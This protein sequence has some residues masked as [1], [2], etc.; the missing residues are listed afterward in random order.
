M[1]TIDKE[2]LRAAVAIH[3]IAQ[4]NELPP[5]AI[6]LP[7]H[8]WSQIQ[9]F[10]RQ[11]NRA[12][13]RG[14][15]A[16]AH[17][18]TSELADACWS[19]QRQLETAFREL[20]R[21]KV[22]RLRPTASAVYHDLRALK[23]EFDAVEIDLQGKEISV[24]T[25]PIELEGIFLGSF[26]IVLEVAQIGQASRPYRIVAV[27]PHAAS[28]REDVTHPHVQAEQL[29]EG[30]G[31]A[32]IAAALAEGRFYDFYVLVDQLLHNYGRGAAFVELSDWY[33]VPCSDCGTTVG[34]DDRY[35]CHGCDST[36][37]ESCSPCCPSC[38]NT[39]CTEC[40]HQCASC[41]DDFCSNCLD[42]CTA[43]RKRFCEGCREDCLCK[44]CDEELSTKETEDEQS[45]DSTCEATCFAGSANE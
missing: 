39:F 38:G 43:C 42:Y 25:D 6:Y 13:E 24:T 12:R 3:A 27:D 23:C 33:G 31:R 41:G 36:L 17:T 11:I 32:A 28:R 5:V 16:A 7:E 20:P 29:C 10:R 34:D 40:L 44:T 15:L 9:K 1:N 30:D 45:D 8:S 4:K 26:Q 14:W 37:C 19:L 2:L 21:Q 22:P 35:Y 18:L